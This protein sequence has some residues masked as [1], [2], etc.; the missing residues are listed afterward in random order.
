MSS[1]PR[2]PGRPSPQLHRPTEDE[3][4]EAQESSRR[5]GPALAKLAA[6]RA[7]TSSV[8]PIRIV[9]KEA[10]GQENELEIPLAALT[11]LQRILAEMAAGNAVTLYPV[12]AELSTQEA[13]DLLGVSRPFLT[14]LLD[15]EEIPCRKVGTHRRILFED[16][17]NYKKVIDDKRTRVLDELAAQAQELGMG[18]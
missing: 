12:H 5:L 2:R 3:S 16:L 14:A 11:L 6:Q 9:I 13:A 15:R 8:A 17:M 10:D 1:L 18:Y 7:L 4:R